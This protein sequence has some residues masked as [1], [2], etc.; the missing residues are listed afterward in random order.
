MAEESLRSTLAVDNVIWRAAYANLH[1]ADSVVTAAVELMVKH[2]S[3]VIEQPQWVDFVKN[4]TDIL[5]EVHRKLSS[6][7]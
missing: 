4:H 3:A 6:K 7:K 5:L 1:K 2:F